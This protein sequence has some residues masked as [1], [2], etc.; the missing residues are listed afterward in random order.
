MKK[1]GG[2]QIKREETSNKK[3]TVRAEIRVGVQT[4]N[5]IDVDKD[6]IDM[7]LI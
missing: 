1:R 6:N 2:N 4:D 5:W 3:G 7:N